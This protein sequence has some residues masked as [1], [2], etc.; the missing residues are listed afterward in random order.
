MPAAK[1]NAKQVLVEALPSEGYP[2]QC[3]LIDETE[4][5]LSS[6]ELERSNTNTTSASN[7]L[8]AVVA[9]VVVGVVVAVVV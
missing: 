2:G 5:E 1:S 6:I 9:K 8:Q 7:L 4:Q 3:V